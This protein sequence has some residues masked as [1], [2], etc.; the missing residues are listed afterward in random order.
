[1][2]LKS[3]KYINTMNIRQITY[4]NLDCRKVRNGFMEKQLSR[5][6]IPY[7]RTTGVVCEDFASYGIVPNI[8]VGSARHKG[9]IGCFLAHKKALLGVL[10]S[11]CG[12]EEMTLVLEDDVKFCDLFWV[13][14]EKSEFPEDA[15]ILFFNA[16]RQYRGKPWPTKNEKDLY[17]IDQGFPMFFGA[18]AYAI[19]KSK[20]REAVEKME[21]LKTYGDV[22]CDFYYT[23]FKCYTLLTKTLA[24]SRFASDRDPNSSFNKGKKI[25]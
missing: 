12:E 15:D 16:T 18:F 14:V 22:D 2:F 1:M 4:I 25:G 8:E 6:K 10:E 24:I 11:D 13:F 3:K 7:S 19:N 9:T 5:Q 23:K 20:A 17:L 21:S